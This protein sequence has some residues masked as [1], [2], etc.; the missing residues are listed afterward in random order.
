MNKPAF[1]SIRSRTA[2]ALLSICVS[3]LGLPCPG[4]SAILTL[5]PSEDAFISEHFDPPTGALTELVI[6][7]QGTTADFDKNRGLVR[8]SDLSQIPTGATITSVRFTITVTRASFGGPV[9]DFR[10]HRLLKPWNDSQCSWALRLAPDVNWGEPGGQAG[11]DYVE[12]SSASQMIGG[13]TAYTF[14]ST[15]TLVDDLNQWRSQPAQNFGWL[16]KT[17]DESISHTGRRVAASG[18][19]APAPTLEITYETEQPLQ[20]SGVQVQGRQLCF[21]FPVKSG[22]SYVVER[23]ETLGQ[24]QWTAFT[25]LTTVASAGTALICDPIAAGSQFYRVGEQ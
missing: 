22:K 4:R 21:Q 17:V 25:N 3:I 5:T 14:E 23:R 8:F 16:I 19:I 10:L 13:P 24:G 7:T 6:G 15:P 2:L 18:G 1:D 11:T 9:A 12:T 20:I